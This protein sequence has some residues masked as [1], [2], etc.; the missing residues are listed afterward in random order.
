MQLTPLLIGPADKNKSLVATKLE[1]M[2][3]RA[4]VYDMQLAP[5]LVGPSNKTKAQVAIELED[6]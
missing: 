4:L 6:M 5:L 2:Q 1:D 3:L